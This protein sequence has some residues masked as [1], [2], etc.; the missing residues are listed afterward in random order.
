MHRTSL[1]PDVL[2]LLAP[3]AAGLALVVLTGCVTGSPHRGRGE[4]PVRRGE[5]MLHLDYFGPEWGPDGEWVYYIKQATIWR[6]G[7]TQGEGRTYFGRIRPD[8]RE[9]TE[10]F[11]LWPERSGNNFV[12]GHIWSATMDIHPAQR[13]AVI[14]VLETRPRGMFTFNLDGSD[15]RKVW[16]E[17]YTPE[18]V[19]SLGWHNHACWSPDGEWIAFEEK[20][21]RQGIRYR[22]CK[23]KEDG[24]GYTVLYPAEADSSADG[25]LPAWHPGD[26]R[27]A[28][29]NHLDG[30]PG[31]CP[32]YTVDAD[33][34]NVVEM[35]R[36]GPGS[37]EWSP[38]GGYLMLDGGILV[39]DGLQRRVRMSD[40]YGGKSHSAGNLPK[41]GTKGW[42]GLW[43][44]GVRYMDVP[45]HTVTILRRGGMTV[46]AE[47]VDDPELRLQ[48]RP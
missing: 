42:L 41:W 24:T 17:A 7:S 3:V 19:K 8:G 12:G 16:P 36:F 23:V 4:R 38:D 45:G 47:E 11:E 39:G 35:S 28:F 9:D 44:E 15:F 20:Y 40:V 6:P 18:F 29:L 34:G 33:G 10:I 5:A 43:D 31:Y 26:S 37:L 25:R 32:V 48:P 13:R 14:S 21:Y 22:I 30:Y 46:P 2:A 27:I 1:T